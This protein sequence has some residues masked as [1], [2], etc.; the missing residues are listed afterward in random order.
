ARGVR[1]YL[2]GRA[3]ACLRPGERLT[4]VLGNALEVPL[5]LLR[6][7]AEH[8]PAPRPGLDLARIA[9]DL[10]AVP[11]QDL[12]LVLHLRDGPEAVP[13]VRVAGRRAQRPLLAAAPDQDR[14]P[15]L[16]RPP[17]DLG[18]R[19]LVGEAGVGDPMAVHEIADD[20]RVLSA[21][22]RA[23]VVSG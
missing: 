17:R 23:V 5:C 22:A 4:V 16:D 15:F 6:V 2:G 11:A 8:D 14:E 9:P 18:V 21:A 12:D 19:H 13:H 7:V 1:G 20:L 10:A 3:R